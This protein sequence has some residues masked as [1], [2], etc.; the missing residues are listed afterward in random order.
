[1]VYSCHDA[2]ITR[3]LV[4]CMFL[5]M[6]SNTQVLYL[7]D[8]LQLSQ[9]SYHWYDC[10]I[11]VMMNMRCPFLV[12]FGIYCQCIFFAVFVRVFLSDISIK[13]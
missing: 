13:I 2:R 8:G 10:L 3:F 7:T 12:H 9:R 1:M 6:L 4:L 11:A 5:F